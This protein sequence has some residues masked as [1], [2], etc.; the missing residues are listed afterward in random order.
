MATAS[1]AHTP[2]SPL[3]TEDSFN[4]SSDGGLSAWLA[5]NWCRNCLAASAEATAEGEV[6]RKLAAAIP[7]AV[8]DVEV[9]LEAVAEPPNKALAG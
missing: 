6:I 5:V 2:S 3:D 8:A 4:L 7:A 9:G 1:V